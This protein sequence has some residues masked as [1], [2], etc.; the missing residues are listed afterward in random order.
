MNVPDNSTLNTI[1]TD[2]V[3]D[4]VEYMNDAAPAYTQEHIDQCREI[5][6]AHAASIKQAPDRAAAKLLVKATVTRLNELNE[7][8]EGE[9]IETLERESICEFIITAGALKGFNT[10]EEDVTEDW[11]EW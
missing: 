7:E 5:L 8:V 2:L 4:M 9:L 1:L 3:S 10:R 11:R 6:V